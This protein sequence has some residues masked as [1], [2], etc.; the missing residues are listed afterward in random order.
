M[1]PNN[2]V[3]ITGLTRV[4]KPKAGRN[5]FIV[6]AYFDCVANGIGMK[7]CAFVRTPKSGLVVWPPRLEATDTRRGL[8]IEDDSLRHAM[9][10]HAREAY[11]ALGGTDAEWVG[12]TIPMGLREA[13]DLERGRAE[14]DQ[15]DEDAGLQRYL[16]PA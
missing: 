1:N 15:V 2:A 9:M 10:Q 16:S 12:S 3:T 7:G 4:A 8:T 5:G 14:D 13:Q 11:R 6:L